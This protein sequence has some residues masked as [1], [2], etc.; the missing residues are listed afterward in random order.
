MKPVNDPGT[1]EYIAHYSGMQKKY[2]PILSLSGGITIREIEEPAVRPEDVMN[3]QQRE[4]FIFSVEGAFRGKTAFTKEPYLKIILST[5]TSC[6]MNTIFYYI[7]LFLMVIVTGFIIY[8]LIPEKNS[9]RK[10]ALQNI[11]EIINTK[12]IN[13][14]PSENDPSTT[15][16]PGQTTLDNHFDHTDKNSLSDKLCEADQNALKKNVKSSSL[17]NPGAKKTN[18]QKTTSRPPKF[19]KKRAKLKTV[20]LTWL[21]INKF[22]GMM[23]KEINVVKNGSFKGFSMNNGLVYITP[24]LVSDTVLAMAKKN[25]LFIK[26]T[27]HR[28]KRNIE[29]SI[30]NILRQKNLIPNFINKKYP[31]TSFSL[32]NLQK[33]Q[34]LTGY[35]TPIKVEAFKTTLAK[36]EK[37]KKASKLLSKITEVEALM[38]QK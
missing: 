28:Q 33:T 17:A 36:L 14:E 4:F 27:G 10:A 29:Y 38:R 21:D 20:D 24:Q 5:N 37:R 18:N 12:T 7:L 32:K 8:L 25:K 34:M 26:E 11:A 2:S 15:V 9:K 22:L 19:K 23:E 30:M 31:G 3:L 35:Y 16:A 1:A 13:Q 6:L